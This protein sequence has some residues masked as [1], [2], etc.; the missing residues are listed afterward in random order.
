MKNITEQF[1][2]EYQPFKVL[3]FYGQQR[4]ENEVHTYEPEDAGELYVESY[5][6]GRHG[7]PVNA[8]PLTVSEMVDLSETFSSAKEM[9]NRYLQS[10]AILP[11]NLLNIDQRTN[12]YAIWY[13]PPQKRDLFFTENLGIPSGIAPVPA[14]VWK[15]T[16][17]T[18]SVFALKGKAKP[19][20]KTALYHAPFLNIYSNGNVCMGNVAIQITKQTNLPAFM[21]LW[22]DYFFQSNFSHSINGSSSTKNDTVALWRELVGS[23]AVFPQEQLVKTHQSLKSLL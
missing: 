2:R 12:G 17:N 23:T 10:R 18:L 22:E 19:N 5:D 9:D 3:L 7:Q 14:M 21:Q 11:S 15:A 20:E 1:N 16:L 6:I 8:H 13:T 4:N